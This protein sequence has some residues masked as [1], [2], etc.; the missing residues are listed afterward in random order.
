MVETLD[1]GSRALEQNLRSFSD[2]DLVHHMKRQAMVAGTTLESMQVFEILRSLE[3]LRSLP[4]VDPRADHDPRQGHR[5]CERHVRG[6]PGRPGAARHRAFAHAVARSGTAL[7]RRVAIHGRL[8]DGGA[9]GAET[10][11]VWRSARAVSGEDVP[12]ARGVF[13][14]VGG[15][16]SDR[17]AGSHGAEHSKKPRQPLVSKQ[18]E[19]E[20]RGDRLRTGSSECW[21]AA[22]RAAAEMRG[23]KSQAPRFNGAC[24]FS[25]SHLQSAAAGRR[26]ANA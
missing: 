5:R 7:S 23:R 26:P 13:A 16:G 25:T 6:A 11:G 4:G 10:A 3:L 2:D 21:R 19:K 8:T 15:R 14:I 18:Q 17:V 1:R 24:D 12:G 20:R 9:S 22:L